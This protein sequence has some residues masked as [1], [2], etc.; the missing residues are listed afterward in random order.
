MD[1]DSFV[2]GLNFIL[3]LILF[4]EAKVLMVSRDKYVNA[5]FDYT[6]LI[7]W[8]IFENNNKQGCRY[9]ENRFSLKTQNP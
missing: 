3:Q 1:W 8:S 4:Y 9:K 7:F 5:V 6:W 2:S